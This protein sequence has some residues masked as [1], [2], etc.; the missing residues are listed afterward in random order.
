MREDLLLR[1]L[2]REDLLHES[3]IFAGQFLTVCLCNDDS[4]FHDI[5]ADF[6]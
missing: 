5:T 6:S 2:T 4:V 1:N 3:L